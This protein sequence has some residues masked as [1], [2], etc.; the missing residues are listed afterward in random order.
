MNSSRG[1]WEVVL[2]GFVKSAFVQTVGP[3]LSALGLLPDLPTEVSYSQ[4]SGWDSLDM[5]LN[6]LIKV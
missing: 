3:K 6:D 2:Y 1:M 5:D 4:A